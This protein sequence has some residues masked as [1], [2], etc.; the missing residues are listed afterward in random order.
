MEDYVIETKEIGDYRIKICRDDDAP[1]P[2]MN[3]DLVGLHLYSDDNNLSSSCNYEEL[4]DTCRYS[5]ADA[6]RSLACM[7]VPQKK[8]IEYINKYLGDSLRFY[9]DRSA[10]M[11]Y[12]KQYYKGMQYN[13]SHWF[14]SQHFTPD[15]VNNQDIRDELSESL[16][17]EDFIY[18]LSNCQTKIAVHEWSSSGHCQGDYAVGFS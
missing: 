1:C 8:F 9:Y 14:E 4:F 11:W 10:H 17:K 18:L 7:Y 12:L 6:V 16:G 3:E 15:E 5:L 2:C 13:G